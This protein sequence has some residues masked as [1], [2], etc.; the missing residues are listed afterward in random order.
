MAIIARG[1]NG[2]RGQQQCT[3]ACHPDFSWLRFP[4]LPRGFHLTDTDFLWFAE[5]K[6]HVLFG[7]CK[8]PGDGER[9]L[10]RLAKGEKDGQLLALQALAA[11]PGVRCFWIEMDGDCPVVLRAVTPLGLGPA[12]ATNQVDFQVRITAW[13]EWVR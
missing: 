1:S 4:G 11:K 12:E 9:L 3:C 10:A 6:H 7:E 13:S 5:R 2:W 8:H